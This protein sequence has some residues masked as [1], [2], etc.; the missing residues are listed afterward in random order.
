M[1]QQFRAS[2]PSNS[3][4]IRRNASSSWSPVSGSIVVTMHR[5]RTE[6]TVGAAL[7]ILSVILNGV[8]AT[9][10]RAVHW[11]VLPVNIDAAPERLW[12][13]HDPQFLA[14]CRGR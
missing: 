8:G 4:R 14:P 6:W 13:W 2:S 9:S 7:F 3:V 10:S 11:N 5:W 12:D 1:T